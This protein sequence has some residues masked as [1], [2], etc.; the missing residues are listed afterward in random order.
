MAEYTKPDDPTGSDSSRCYPVK[1]F[2][3]VTANEGGDF[4][5]HC[6]MPVLPVVGQLI[7]FT[8]SHWVVVSSVDII[9]GVGLVV[10]CVEDRIN[11]PGIADVLKNNGFKSYFEVDV[12]R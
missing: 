6:D 3:Q 11:D 1:L 8:E 5:K 2:C 7:R 10:C 12:Y 4:I 9:F